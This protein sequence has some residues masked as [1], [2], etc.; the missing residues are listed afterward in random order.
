MKI[1]SEWFE[2]SECKRRG[3]NPDFFFP[4]MD[5]RDFPTYDAAKSVCNACPVKDRCLDNA[6]NLYFAE[7]G[8][9]G[10]LTRGQRRGL[11]KVFTKIPDEVFESLAESLL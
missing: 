5:T 4:D 9:H 6:L 11:R 1:S 10:G 2:Q 3:L 7:D 8:M